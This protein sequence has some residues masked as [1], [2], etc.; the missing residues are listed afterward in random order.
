MALNETWT[1]YQTLYKRYFKYISL[2]HVSYI[3]FQIS[4]KFVTK[5]SIDKESS[6]IQAMHLH[7]KTTSHNLD[8]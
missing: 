2:K 7:Q 5:S 1:Q 3:L 8:Q 4:T 6:L